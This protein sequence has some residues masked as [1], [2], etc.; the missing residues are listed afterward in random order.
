[1]IEDRDHHDDWNFILQLQREDH[2]EVM[3]N[4]R[5]PKH[6]HEE[7]RNDQRGDRP[8]FGVRQI[9]AHLLDAAP[10]NKINDA[11][12]RLN[13]IGQHL[14]LKVRR[15]QGQ[16]DEEQQEGSFPLTP[17]DVRQKRK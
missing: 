12:S 9:M 15:I 5:D 4:T 13:I 2:V 8:E 10:C 16:N 11:L 14:R 17:C 3:L 7:W 1:M 6:L